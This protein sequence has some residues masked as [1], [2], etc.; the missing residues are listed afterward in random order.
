MP[1]T[2][3]TLEVH[4]I[5][6]NDVTTNDSDSRSDAEYSVARMCCVAAMIFRQRVVCLYTYIDVGK[7]AGSANSSRV[8]FQGCCVNLLKGVCGTS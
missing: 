4:L 8:C 7:S 1:P 2:L 5:K 6:S 3:G